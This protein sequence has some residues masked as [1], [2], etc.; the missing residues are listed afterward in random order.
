MASGIDKLLGRDV[1]EIA[2][3]KKIN[4]AQVL[5]KGLAETFRVKPNDPK[6]YFAKFLLNYA[7]EQE[8]AHLVSDPL[9]LPA[10]V[11]LA[12]IA[13]NAQCA[14]ALQHANSGWSSCFT[15]EKLCCDRGSRGSRMQRNSVKNAP[16]S[17]RRRQSRRL[18]WP[19]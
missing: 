4:I 6:T 5:N 17:A 11:M 2:Y 13:G 9:K 7:K 1:A 19:K 12:S 3:L 8:I 15:C 10:T 16:S 14:N 18:P